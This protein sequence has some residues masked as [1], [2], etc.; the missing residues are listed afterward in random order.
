VISPVVAFAEWIG[1]A[2]VMAGLWAWHVRLRDARVADAGWTGLVA[3][4]AIV[5][6]RF[7]D[8]FG[9]RR[10]AIAFMLGSW[11][12][13][14]LVHVLYERVFARTGSAPE[15]LQPA[16]RF[17]VQALLA[18]VFSIPALVASANPEPDFTRVELAAAGL[19]IV[20]FAGETTADRHHRSPAPFE[21]LIWVACAM[22]AWPSAWG[23][24]ALACPVIRGAQLTVRPL[25]DWVRKYRR[26]S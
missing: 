3:A 6:A 2:A 8:G 25:A 22:F 9:P 17:Q 26:A 10:A 14:L 18:I 1:A 21:W 12:L 15:D 7:S 13:R 20:G 24:L 5:D 16:W 4:L 11:G 23:W 19:W